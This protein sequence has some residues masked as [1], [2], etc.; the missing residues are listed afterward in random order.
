MKQ[1]EVNCR[2]R[3]ED[4]ERFVTEVFLRTG[5]PRQDAV[6]TA[7]TIVQ[8][9]LRGVATHGVIRLP[10]YVRRFKSG[11]MNPTPK[12]R[13]VRE[14]GPLALLDGDNGMGQ[15]VSKRAMEECIARTRTHNV[16]VVLVR[17][18]NHFGVAATYA[19][20]AADQG[21]VGLCT[22][23][24]F[25]V[26]A[27]AGGRTPLIGNNPIAIAVPGD[28]PIVID[29]ALSAV[30]RGNI[31]VAA[32]A[33]KA[34]PEG[35]GFDAEGRPTTDPNAILN[36]GSLSPVAYHKGSGLSIII[37]A[38]LAT[39]S[40]GGYGYQG[41]GLMDLSGQM[42][43][44]HLFGAIRV[45]ALVPL[46]DFRNSVNAFATVLRQSPKAAGTE[47][48]LMPGEKELRIERS[49]SKEGIPLSPER[50]RELVELADSLAIEGLQTF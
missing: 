17:E 28:P 42:H 15:V 36:G 21:M 32:Q 40:G 45:D 12:I 4:L 7:M 41:K 16:G 29:I 25:P 5:M 35:W 44:T 27:P 43:V 2:V 48:I 26:M 22:T 9:E 39:L 18:S 19:L 14:A 13:L 8:S 31:N 47:R 23:N 6:W 11:L 30:A 1:E 20:M 38:I 33:G 34:V 24:T 37:D 46:T 50:Q 49:L 10:Y 3:A